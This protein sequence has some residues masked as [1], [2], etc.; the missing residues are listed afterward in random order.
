MKRNY[1]SITYTICACLLLVGCL[2]ISSCSK[3][4]S[5]TPSEKALKLL[6]GTWHISTVTVD[7]VDKTSQFAGFALT[8]VPGL[9]STVATVSNPVWSAAGTW[10]FTDN[11][12]TSITRDDNVVVNITSLTSTSLTLTLQ[13]TKT[14]YGGGRTSSV[15]GTHVFTLNK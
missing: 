13:W 11:N 8:L 5:E 10:S 14:T 7:G 15:S 9:Y 12:A 2:A 6:T 3:S 4:S 1:S